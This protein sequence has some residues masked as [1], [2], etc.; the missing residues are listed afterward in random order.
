MKRMGS[1]TVSGTDTKTDAFKLASKFMFGGRVN[2]AD[3]FKLIVD[4]KDKGCGFKPTEDTAL[5]VEDPGRGFSANCTWAGD[6]SELFGVVFGH[7]VVTEEGRTYQSAQP[8][9]HVC[10]SK[11][12][13]VSIY[14]KWEIENGRLPKTCLACRPGGGQVPGH[15]VLPESW[16]EFTKLLFEEHHMATAYNF[17]ADERTNMK[18][19]EAIAD[20]EGSGRA[21]INAL[22][23]GSGLDP[24]AGWHVLVHSCSDCGSKKSERGSRMRVKGV[25]EGTRTVRLLVQPVGSRLEFEV[26]LSLKRRDADFAAVVKAIQ[27][28]ATS[29]RYEAKAELVAAAAGGDAPPVVDLLKLRDGIDKLIAVR[30]DLDASGQVAAEAAQKVADA[31]LKLEALKTQMDNAAVTAR[32]HHLK[33]LDARKREQDARTAAATALSDLARAEDAHRASVE[34]CNET[35]RLLSAAAFSVSEARKSATEADRLA[36]EIAEPFGGMRRLAEII[37]HFS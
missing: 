11:C 8:D 26:H 5:T 20:W 1:V 33:V 9:A 18:T 13:V 29:R 30:K 36:E 7:W 15:R 17:T 27:E 37:K 12:G 23:V 25:Q 21:A 19:K 2:F 16:V 32:A 28:Y 34:Q 3:K 10:M 24:A 14:K 4:P 31:E 6:A 22:V 35:E